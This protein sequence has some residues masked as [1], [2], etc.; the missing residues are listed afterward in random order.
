MKGSTRTKSKKLP[1][2][3]PLVFPLDRRC[4]YFDVGDEVHFDSSL[5]GIGVG[6]GKI[7]KITKNPFG[8]I[9]YWVGEQLL[10]VEDI[11][12]PK[13]IRDTEGACSK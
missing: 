1:D 9:S 4:R 5:P 2:K 7:T 10:L 3:S 8:R 12:A 11:C 13:K 6:H